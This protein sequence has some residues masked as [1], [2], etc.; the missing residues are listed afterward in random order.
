MNNSNVRLRTAEQA[1][2]ELLAMDP[3]TAITKYYIRTLLASG[4]L[5][6][7]KIGRKTLVN[8][9]T[10]IEHLSNAAKA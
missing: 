6:V 9:D 1:Y 2:N 4:T 8:M 3:D 7:T 10:L 5:P